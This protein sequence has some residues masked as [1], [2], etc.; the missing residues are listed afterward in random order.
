MAIFT[1]SKCRGSWLHRFNM[2]AR[3]QNGIQERCEICGKKVFFR[4]IDGKSNNTDYIS[5]HMRQV[6]I[7]Q[8]RLFFHEWPHLL[9]P[10]NKAT[11][12]HG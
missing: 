8:H 3:Y 12:I 4:V 6:L 7:P 11:S 10:K 9:R 2:V 5:Y 1:R